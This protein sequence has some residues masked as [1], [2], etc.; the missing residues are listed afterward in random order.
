[1]FE[2]IKG[3]KKLSFNHWRYRLLHWAFN[4][5]NPH[6][7]DEL[8]EFLY[9]HYCPL[10]H[11]TNLIALLSPLVLLI[12]LMVLGFKGL[13]A[14]FKLLPTDKIKSALSNFKPKDKV[15]KSSLALDRKNCIKCICDFQGDFEEFWRFYHEWKHLKKEEAALLFTE[16]MPKVIEGRLKYKLR[17]ERWRNRIIFW[18]NFSRVFIK[19]A[20][21]VLYFALAGLF[22]YVAYLV[23]VP[24]WNFMCW[25]VDFIIWLFTDAISLSLF[26]FIAK[27]LLYGTILFI[28]IIF[29]LKI[30]FFGVF[31]RT[32]SNGLGYI[33]PPFYLLLVP[34]RWIR[35]GFKATR[36]FVLMFYEEN[37]PPI[38]LVNDEEA[39]VESKTQNEEI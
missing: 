27:I 23:S 20:M 13:C 39:I 29:I 7:G 19:W 4:V 1:M 21:N 17:K 32:I 18:T 10:F 16:Y 6:A 35:D 38:T 11:L 33:S 34:F 8:P 37:C 2:S 14:C 24:I 3:E 30:G 15:E 12:K 25:S 31:S 22:L 9:T 5:E 26:F 36:E 28:G